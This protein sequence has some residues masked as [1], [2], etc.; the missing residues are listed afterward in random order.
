MIQQEVTTHIACPVE[1]V[2]AFLTDAKNL[3]AWQSNLIENQQ[4]TEGTVRVG[5]Q[6]REV[7]RTGPR[8]S[9]IRA[10]I[11][12]YDVNKRFATKTLTKPQ[13]T[14]DYAMESEAGGTRLN[15]K[16]VMITSGIMRLLE[17]LIAGSM[18]KDND[19]DFQKLKSILEGK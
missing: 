13:V 14:V 10:E 12:A 6:F 11:T 18:K 4:L 3:R 8:H 7:R 16:F 19:L 9:E 17:P 1:K 5:T 2:F 15:Y